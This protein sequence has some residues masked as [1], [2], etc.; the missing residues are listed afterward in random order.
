MKWFFGLYIFAVLFISNA[1]AQS[2]TPSPE[3]T[4]APIAQSVGSVVDKIP[5]A[6]SAGVL[7][8]IAIIIE[9][10]L[11]F[12]PTARPKSLFLMLAQVTGYIGVGFTKIS[13]I[14]DSIV[15][16]LKDDPPK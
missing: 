14:L 16:R 7:A 1:I 4:L 11:R 15:Q 8:M 12:F 6:L 2:P 13:N 3:P 5:T 10:G 9:L